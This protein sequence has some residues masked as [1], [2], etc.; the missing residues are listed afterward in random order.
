MDFNYKK[1]NNNNLFID[2]R[3]EELLNIEES[4]NYIPLYDKFFKLNEN[5]FNS[6]NLNNQNSLVN[7][8]E[9]INE[10]KYKAKIKTGEQEITNKNVFFKFSPLLDP[11]K[12]L[13]GKYEVN[14]NLFNLPK[15]GSNNGHS[16]VFRYNNTAYVDSFFTYLTSQLLNKFNFIHGLDFYGS[17]LG[18]KKEYQVDICEDV[19][20]IGNSDFF[21]ENKNLY[22][23]LNLNHENLFN[24]DS[25]RKAAQL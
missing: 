17:F 19:D 12:Y 24:Q 8:I 4:Q 7:I 10:N 13:A 6:I 9:K 22:K 20:M 15:F 18:I 25:R 1:I 16:K 2:F 5:N 23:F 14:E 3:K 21:Y 11:F